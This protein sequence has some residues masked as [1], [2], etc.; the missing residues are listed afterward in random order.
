MRQER[1][2]S[3][4]E[5]E[6]YIRNLEWDLCVLRSKL[7]TV[8]RLQVKEHALT[9]ILSIDIYLCSTCYTEL[10]NEYKYCPECGQKIDWRTNL[11]R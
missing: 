5:Q 2:F 8:E 7:H 9:P 11:W 10:L 1:S 6:E 4:T 3:M